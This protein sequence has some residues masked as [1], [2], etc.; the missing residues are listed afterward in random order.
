MNNTQRKAA[1]IEICWN[2]VFEYKATDDY[3]TYCR[4]CGETDTV[5]EFSDDIIHRPDCLIFKAVEVLKLY[6]EDGMPQ[7]Y[8]TDDVIPEPQKPKCNHDNRR[9]VGTVAPENEKAVILYL[10][11]DCGETFAIKQV[12]G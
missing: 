9:A 2:V 5:G 7:F 8:S 10:C 11:H 1:V 6:D 4:Y 12:I 3:E